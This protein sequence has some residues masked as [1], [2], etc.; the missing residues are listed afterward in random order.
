M[1]IKNIQGNTAWIRG[2]TNTGVYMFDDGTA[3]LIDVGL[4]GKRQDKLRDILDNKKVVPRYIFSTHEH[5]DH[6][7]GLYQMREMYDGIDIYASK[8][9]KFHIEHPDEYVDFLIG[10]RRD[11]SLVDSMLK[12]VPQAGKVDFEVRAGETVVINGHEFKIV[13]CSGHTDEGIGIIT[14]DKVAFFGDLMITKNSLEK[15]DFLFMY[16]CEDHKRTLKMVKDYDFEKAVLGHTRW[17]YT[18]EETVDI[19]E[20]NYDTLYRYLEFILKSCEKPKNIEEIVAHFIKVKKLPYDY[21][22]YLE[23]RNSVMA[24]ISYLMDQ[25]LLSHKF[26]GNILKYYS[27]DEAKEGLFELFYEE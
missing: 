17:L 16:N 23:Y 26:E 3:V 20:Y 12:Y 21:M 11:K 8:K 27:L 18:K 6:S 13:D 24:G 4:G 15:F 2:G 10:G 1:D 5:S 14:D 9:S 7:G 25:G 19:A 22:S